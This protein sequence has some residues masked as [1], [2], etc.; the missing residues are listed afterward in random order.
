MKEE[1]KKE[2][3]GVE[4]KRHSLS[5]ILAYAVKEMYPEAKLSIGPSIE[6]GFY[7]DIDFGEVKINESN[8]KEIEKKMAYLIKQNLK[9]ERT[10]LPIDEGIKKEKTE[11]EI[12]KQELITDLKA[13]GETIVSYYTVGKFTDLCRGPHVTNTNQ[14]KPGSYKLDKLAGAYWRGDEKNKMLTRIYGLAF[15][16]KE[17]LADYLK[18]M[19]EAEKRDHR[20]ICKE[21][22]LTMLHEFAPGIPFFLPKGFIILNELIKF[23]REYSYGEGYNEVR[24]PQLYNAELW[25][26]SGHWDHYQEDMFIL[27]HAE[28]DCDLGIKPMNCPGHMLIFKNSTRSYSDLP[29]RIAETTTL[30]RNEKSG[31]LQGLTRVRSISQDDTHIFARPDQILSEIATLLEKIKNIYAIFNL[32][33]DEIHLSTRPENFMGEKAV[34]DKAEDNL[35]TAL[36]NAGLNYKINEGDGAFY[37]PKIDVKVKDAIG[38]QWQLATIQLDFQLPK[39]FELSYTNQNGEKITPIVIHRALLGS[40]ERF[41]GVIIEHYSGIMPVWLSPVQIKIV[42]VAETHIPHCKKLAAELKAAGIR[43]EIDEANETVG[44]KIRK[45]VNEKVPYMLVIGD[46]EVNSPLLNVRDRGSV[47][48][49]EIATTDF[50]KEVSYKIKSHE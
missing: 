4:V 2:D 29:L 49:R 7:Y 41:M 39:R 25:K 6:N 30:Y 12:Y 34:W 21:Q 37:G 46:K 5:H 40:M 9:F 14:I 44:N 1:L 43:V 26:I 23:V 16:T 47:K 3:V 27:H 22:D 35:K 10:E 11:G 19:A 24:T 17:E 18:M 31:T 28:D 33:I 8:L 15:N 50:I 32:M 13:K 45:A 42:S 20:K 38:R 36:D 48:T